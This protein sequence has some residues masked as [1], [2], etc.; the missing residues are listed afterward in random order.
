[1]DHPNVVWIS[2]DTTRA[3]A[4]SCYGV[5]A[6]PHRVPT[7]TTPHLDE[8]AQGG[9]RFE[10]FYAHAPSTLSSHASM[11]TGLDPHEHAVVR[12]GFP[13]DPALP[14][15]AERLAGAGWDTVAV[16]GSAA[17][18]RSMGL[19]RGFRLY[20]DAVTN[21]SGIMFQRSAEEVVAATFTAL[22]G[23]PDAG[24]PL[25]LFAHF[26]DP[27]A[28][29]NPP[30]PYRS[31][32]TDPAYTG[33]VDPMDV[34]SFRQFSQ[35]VR[36]GQAQPED[37]SHVSNL[38][39]GEVAYMDAQ[40]GRLLA[41][42]QERGLLEHA[43]VIVVADHGETLAD[44]TMYAWSH[45]SNVGWEVMRVP[46][47]VRGYGMPLAEHA[48]IERQAGMDGLASTVLELVGLAP[49]GDGLSFASWLR[50]GPAL[51]VEGWPE[52][53]TIPVYLEATRPRIAE[54]PDAW[55]NLYMHRGVWASGWG[56]VSAPFLEHPPRFQDTGLAPD[57]GV[58]GLLTAMLAAW[59]AR[60]P[61]HAAPREAPSTT[62]ALKALGYV[63]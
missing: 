40:V 11:F 33:S 48:V 32:F 27:H 3:D 8:L 34:P 37:L 22:D 35:E 2:L 52:H 13:L 46:L 62:R 44:D 61:E 30:E 14:T 31:R 55:N 26:Y 21:L 57:E 56:L 4:L 45:G 16:L 60:A 17:L 49:V 51:D 12:N 15:L 63:E 24:A 36:H 18:E 25:F 43:L 29:Y 50:A 47:L 7:L 53:P 9:I 42:L 39:L 38:Y 1:M 59:D 5:P 19:D 23:R 28:P 58:R 6:G 10:R 20:D 41:G 54:T